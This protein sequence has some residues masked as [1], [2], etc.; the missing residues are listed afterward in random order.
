MR[1]PLDESWRPS[2]ATMIPAFT[3]SSLNFPIS[4]SCSVVGRIP[5]SESL[6]ALTITMKRIV[7]PVSLSTL[8]LCLPCCHA[9]DEREL[10][11]STQL[12]VAG[13]QSLTRPLGP[14]NKLVRSGNTVAPRLRAHCDTPK[15]GLL[16]K[17]LAVV[18]VTLASVIVAIPMTNRSQR[19]ELT[20]GQ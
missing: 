3:S 7:P 10:R 8:E 17:A 13:I 1:T 11:K 4:A 2:P 16:M 19:S 20:E 5:A 15:T 12:E 18:G 14:S 9:S 6:L